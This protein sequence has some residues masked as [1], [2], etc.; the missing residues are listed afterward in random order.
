VP[1]G[2][3]APTGTKLDLTLDSQGRAVREHLY[4]K[5]AKMARARAAVW[6]NGCVRYGQ[7]CYSVAENTNEHFVATAD[8][9][10]SEGTWV[11]EPLANDFVTHEA[12]DLFSSGYFFETGQILGNG[13]ACCNWH[14][15]VAW[16]NA[17]EGFQKYE[18]WWIELGGTPTWSYEADSL[19]NGSWVI[20]W[21]TGQVATLGGF[22]TSTSRLVVGTEAAD[23]TWPTTRGYDNTMGEPAGKTGWYRWT[24]VRFQI[25]PGMCAG[26]NTIVPATGNIVY[27]TQGRC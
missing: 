21:P 20:Y 15:F 10:S 22:A 26:P 18:A 14:P 27:G 8:Y 17:A 24:S 12:W 9:L 6:A 13:Y 3:P 11:P 25:Y 7:H 1:P 2:Y 23:E 5:Q 4:G 19:G 16:E